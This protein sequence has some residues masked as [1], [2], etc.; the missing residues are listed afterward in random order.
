MIVA[1]RKEHHLSDSDHV[2]VGGFDHRCL[3][4]NGAQSQN[5]HLRLIDDGRTEDIAKGPDVRNRVGSS[6]D[7][8]WL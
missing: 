8:V 4:S 2:P 3:L 5:A 7:F 6:T 1:V